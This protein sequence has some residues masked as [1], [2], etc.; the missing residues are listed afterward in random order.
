VTRS[1]S[2]CVLM[3]LSPP[4]LSFNTR[5]SQNPFESNLD[6]WQTQYISIECEFIGFLPSSSGGHI[7]PSR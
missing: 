6:N 3:P 4:D 2:D 7:V 5:M 1:E